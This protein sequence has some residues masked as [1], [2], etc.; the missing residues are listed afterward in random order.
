MSFFLKGDALKHHDTDISRLAKSIRTTLKHRKG[1]ELT[2]P[3]ALEIVC[4][5][6]GANT[7]YAARMEALDPVIKGMSLE[8]VDELKRAR[9]ITKGAPVPRDFLEQND[10]RQKQHPNERIRCTSREFQQASNLFDEAKQL[11]TPGRLQF[12]AVVGSQGAGKSVLL[13][14]KV[15]K[16]GGLKI[17]TSQN[18]FDRGDYLNGKKIAYQP[19]SI[20]AYDRPAGLHLKKRDAFAAMR[21]HQRG[22]ITRL[23]QYEALA[24]TSSLGI[25]HD[26]VE[27]RHL[28][29]WLR[30]ELNV[31][32]VVAFDSHDQV[33]DAVSTR[34]YRM[35][36]ALSD[37]NWE[38]VYV[39]NLDD[40]TLSQIEITRDGSVTTVLT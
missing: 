27:F 28:R 36:G 10:C 24:A 23:S 33:V 7:L 29:N 37:D 18:C 1:V 8:Q 2:Q 5:G 21:E 17:D 30:E 31:T 6:L 3:E 15:D 40:M 39:V 12:I 13:A 19:G 35:N 32:L 25:P 38:R 16:F 11:I 34:I 22:A 4:V 14:D 9:S 26:D 20:L